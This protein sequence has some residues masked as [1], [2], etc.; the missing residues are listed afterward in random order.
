[1]L[2]TL[3]VKST[4]FD[5]K[6][7]KSTKLETAAGINSNDRFSSIVTEEILWRRRPNA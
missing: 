2:Q 6:K 7:V 3:L 4:K 1:M 5:Q